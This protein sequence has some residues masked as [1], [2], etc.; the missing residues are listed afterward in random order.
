MFSCR[1]APEGLRKIRNLEFSDLTGKRE[2][3]MQVLYYMYGMYYLYCVYF[4]YCVF[5]TPG[6][7]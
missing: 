2:E 3:C 7:L 5:F 6:V 4:V 1:G